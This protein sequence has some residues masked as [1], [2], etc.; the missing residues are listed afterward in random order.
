MYVSCRKPVEGA[1]RSLRMYGDADCD[2]NDDG[3]DGGA[4]DFGDGVSGGVY[5]EKQCRAASP[6]DLV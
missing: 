2:A 1:H 4:K 3:G 6:S 5:D